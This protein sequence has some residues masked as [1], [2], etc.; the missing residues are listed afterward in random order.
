M[1]KEPTIVLLRLSLK[2][3]IYLL[4]GPNGILNMGSDS[5]SDLNVPM[6]EGFSR[7]NYYAGTGYFSSYAKGG[8]IGKHAGLTG[9]SLR[10]VVP[11]DQ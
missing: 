3:K 7:P 6:T 5:Q 4:D 9:L 1:E 8:L 2:M 11:L 10:P